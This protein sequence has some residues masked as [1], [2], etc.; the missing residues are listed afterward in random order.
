MRADGPYLGESHVTSFPLKMDPSKRAQRVDVL[1]K[2][3]VSSHVD[4]GRQEGDTDSP[5]LRALSG[6]VGVGCDACCVLLDSTI[7]LAQQ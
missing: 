4:P 6:R 1:A 2:V 7:M 5:S 3:P